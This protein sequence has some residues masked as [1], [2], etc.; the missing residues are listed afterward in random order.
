MQVHLGF[1]LEGTQLEFSQDL[2][3]QIVHFFFQ[4]FHFIFQAGLHFFL[5]NQYFSSPYLRKFSLSPR[6][7][8]LWGGECV[9]P[10]PCMCTHIHFAFWVSSVY[11]KPA[12]QHSYFRAWLPSLQKDSISYIILFM[13]YCQ[14]E[15]FVFLYVPRNKPLATGRHRKY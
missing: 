6:T 11:V 3:W 1:F 14:V 9:S 15:S 5:C 4:L 13:D 12:S 8:S 7:R 10:T 2:T